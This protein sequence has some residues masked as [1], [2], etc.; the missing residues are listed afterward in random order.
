MGFTYNSPGTREWREM[1]DWIATSLTDQPVGFIFEI[2]PSDFIYHEDREQDVACV[3]AQVLEDG[4]VMLRRSREM[5]RRLHL[6]SFATH[7]LPID[8]WLMDG[9]FDD[10]TDGYI[11]SRDRDLIAGAVVAWF[12]DTCGV[13]SP[14]DLG[15]EYRGPDTLLPDN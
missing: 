4:V 10:C 1:A 13:Q 12:R 3:Q 6:A 14:D 8:R 2:G 7:G 9:H 15:C 11:F 5:L